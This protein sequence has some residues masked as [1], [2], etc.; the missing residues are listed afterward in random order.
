MFLLSTAQRWCMERWVVTERFLCGDCQIITT[1]EEGNAWSSQY[2]EIDEQ[3]AE[4]VKALD[5]QRMTT[6]LL[7]K[8]KASV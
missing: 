5:G 7:K 6:E 8:L 1:T 2:E 4:T 3:I